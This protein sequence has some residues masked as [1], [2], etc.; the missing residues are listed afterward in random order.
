M[1]LNKA[2]IHSSATSTK[3]LIRRCV[4][5]LFFSYYVYALYFLLL[6]VDVSLTELTFLL[7]QNV[8][9]R[10][11]YRKVHLVLTVISELQPTKPVRR[12][13]FQTFESCIACPFLQRQNQVV[14]FIDFGQNHFDILLPFFS[15]EVSPTPI[16]IDCNG[17][18]QVSC[19]LVL[20]LLVDNVMI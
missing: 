5:L 9:T 2:H 15:E 18:G 4:L 8:R 13:D 12:A 1:I 7:L 10:Q 16:L 11:F 3:C 14:N 17:F 20:F 6:L 19:F